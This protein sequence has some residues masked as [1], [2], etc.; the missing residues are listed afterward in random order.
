MEQVDPAGAE[1][2]LA[3]GAVLVDVREAH[4]WAAGHAEQAIHLPL[5][6]LQDRVGELDKDQAYVVTCKAGGRSAQA[7]GWLAPQGFNVVNLDGGMQ[8]W[9]ASGRDL[10][11]ENGDAGEVIAP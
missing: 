3:D 5:S 11:D 8:G 9:A 10:V 7:I 6:E 2:R 1:T 4:E